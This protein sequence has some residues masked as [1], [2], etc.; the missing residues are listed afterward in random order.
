MESVWVNWKVFL[1]R[2][3]ALDRS[4]GKPV[5]VITAKAARSDRLD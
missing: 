3:A 1:D 2:A 4:L 5:E